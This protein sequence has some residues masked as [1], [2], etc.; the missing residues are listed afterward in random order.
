MLRYVKV[1]PY[2]PLIHV[3]FFAV[4]CLLYLYFGVFW[5]AGYL[6][7][8]DII[9]NCKVGIAVIKSTKTGVVVMVTNARRNPY[10]YV[11]IVTAWLHKVD[12]GILAL[13]TISV[14]SLFWCLYYY[15]KSLLYNQFL[16]VFLY[17]F[18]LFFVL[19]C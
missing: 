18:V 1:H 15:C 14:L 16:V 9:L 19:T 10:I 5:L 13:V 6:H 11:L 7:V 12:V 3:S 4:T 8:N 2:L 17:L